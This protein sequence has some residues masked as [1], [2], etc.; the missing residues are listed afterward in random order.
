MPHKWINHLLAQDASSPG[1]AALVER[2]KARYEGSIEAFN[3]V[4][5]T[6]FD[7]FEDLLAS[8]AIR[9][10]AALNPQP[11]E[12][13]DTPHKRDFDQLVY[14]VIAQ[15]HAVA[16]RH[17]R[18]ADPNHLIFGFYFKTYNANLGLFEAIAPYVDVLS[19]QH[20]IVPTY[21]ADGAFDVNAGVIDVEA[22]HQR[23]G[24]PIYHGDQWLGKVVPGKPGSRSQRGKIK[25]PYFHSQEYRGQVYEALLERVL[26]FPQVVG[27]AGC[28]TLYDNPDIDGSH[29]GNKGLFD[30]QLLEKTAFTTYVENTN[31]KLYSL[32]TK[33]YDPAAIQVLTEK[34]VKTMDRAAN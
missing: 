21:D 29:G 30:K 12:T 20:H 2:L 11:G 19:P 25:Y 26:A 23:T 4:Y 16:H 18:A 31:R 9:Y 33:I 17:I 32:R 10:D 13:L 8:T 6:A 24:K 34:A 14:T 7:G 22:I 27:F 5:N 3:V 28:A 15:V 1:K